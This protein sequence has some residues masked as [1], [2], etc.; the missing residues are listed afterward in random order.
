MINVFGSRILIKFRSSKFVNY[1]F[2][3]ASLMGIHTFRFNN[4]TTFSVQSLHLL[5][6]AFQI[7]YLA[8]KLVNS[9]TYFI[10][11]PAMNNINI[12]LRQ[13]RTI[14][15]RT[16][17]TNSTVKSRN[18]CQSVN[19]PELTLFSKVNHSTLYYFLYLQ[20]LQL[21]K[22]STCYAMLLF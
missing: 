11:F 13:S 18:L 17:I 14:L 7:A 5:Y 10:Y 3:L 20:L 22:P 12:L 9:S 15:C 2:S 21:R 16:T 6:E 19:L 4:G 1:T 8:K